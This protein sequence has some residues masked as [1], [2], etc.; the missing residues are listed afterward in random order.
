MPDALRRLLADLIG[1]SRVN[2]P[3]MSARARADARA[4]E[5]RMLS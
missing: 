5:G 4:D 3:A 1:S 2:Q